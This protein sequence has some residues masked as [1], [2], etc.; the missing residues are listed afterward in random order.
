MSRVKHKLYYAFIILLTFVV[1]LAAVSFAYYTPETNYSTDLE[2]GNYLIKLQSDDLMDNFVIVEAQSVKKIRINVLNGSDNDSSFKIS[3]TS[4]NS[5]VDVYTLD[6]LKDKFKDIVVIGDGDKIVDTYPKNK[7]VSKDE[8]IFILTNSKNIEIPDFIGYSK[9][10]VDTYKK[11]T[12][13]DITLEGN[14]YVYE[15]NK[16]D[17]KIY[18]KLKDRYVEQK[19]NNEDT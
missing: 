4:D 14:G 10:E 5:L 16:E 9:R 13:I 18:L 1:S 12:G 17:D 11:L 8:K 6:N 15:Q 3:Y 7:V 2:V 19:K